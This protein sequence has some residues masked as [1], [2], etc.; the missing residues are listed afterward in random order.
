MVDLVRL[1]TYNKRH[2]LTYTLM[3][4]SNFTTYDGVTINNENRK[5]F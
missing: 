4:A 1:E 2:S 3:R 5:R